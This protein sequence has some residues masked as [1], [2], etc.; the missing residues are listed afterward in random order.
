MQFIINTI[1]STVGGLYVFALL[2]RFLMQLAKVNFYNPVSQ[3]FI[4]LTNPLV[5]PLTKIIPSFYN[6]NLGVLI[7]AVA[8]QMAVSG[9]IVQYS[10]PISILVAVSCL[11]ILINILDIYLY[12]MVI[13]AVCSWIMPGNR[14]PLIE[15]LYQLIEPVVGRIRQI[16]PSTSGID[17]S[18]MVLAFVIYIVKNYIAMQFAI[19]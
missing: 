8:V 4:N 13:L 1:V 2:A 16:I 15:L 17:F 18:Y 5:R 3:I 12:S 11:K 7:L 10:I 14:S 19:S 6:F 9:L